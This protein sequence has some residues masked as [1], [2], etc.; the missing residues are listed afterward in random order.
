[1][2]SLFSD[3]AMHVVKL[4]E[5]HLKCLCKGAWLAVDQAGKHRWK[6]GPECRA[7]KKAKTKR[8]RMT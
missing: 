5:T 1:M 8:A 4:G 2:N 6:C 3:H 7:A